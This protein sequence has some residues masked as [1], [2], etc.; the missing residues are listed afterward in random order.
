MF[1]YC[2]EDDDDDDVLLF[3]SEAILAHKST[4]KL[5]IQIDLFSSNFSLT[6]S[7]FVVVVVVLYTS[8]ATFTLCHRFHSRFSVGEGG[9]ER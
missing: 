2:D 9:P 7:H 3:S 4:A 6:V 1:S 8:N 5:D